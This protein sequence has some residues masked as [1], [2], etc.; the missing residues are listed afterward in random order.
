MDR[1][2]RVWVIDDDRSIRW[3]L[4]KT[5]EKA[6]MEVTSFESA[7][8]VLSSLDK[9]QP[10][11]VV[12]DIRMPG[13]DGLE[14]LE[15]LH[16]RYP[17]LPV[18]IMTA[19][20][21]LDS[22]VSAYHGGAFEYL[23]K[24]FDVDEAVQQIRRACRQQLTVEEQPQIDTSDGGKE[25][26][27]EAP[28]M[29]EVFRAIGRLARSNITVLINGESGTGKELVAHALHR[30]SSRAEGPFIALNMAAI[31]KDL[32]E[33]EL[34]G[35]ERG[36]FTGAQTRRVGRFEQADSGTLF[37]D[38]IGDMPA[39]L[40]T[41]L[42]RVLADGEFYRVGGHEPVKV[43]VRIIAATHQHLE[44]LVKEGA[45]R[46]DLF[47]RLNV[48]RIHLPSLRQR[49]EDIPLLLNYFLKTA[50]EELAV[51][52]KVLLPEAESYLSQLEWPGNVRQ[53][54]NTARWLTVMASGQEIH[55]DD[56][57]TELKESD[58]STSDQ[59]DWRQLLRGWV[60]RRLQEGCEGI[61]NEAEPD[62]ETVM[63]ET[64][65]EHTAGKRQ[66]AARLL[67]W[68]RNTLTRKIKELG[69]EES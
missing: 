53:L 50:A 29:Q 56:L 66:D 20:S 18:I 36:A 68:G 22:A 1:A 60:K 38:E 61:L 39:E 49:R 37:L 26:I 48:I 31:P 35:H 25:I 4:E 21:D 46:E 63:I 27:G 67:G 24:P 69:M 40:Q 7:D 33:S 13:M 59:D 42:L 54:E 3:V 58:T 5:L 9:G 15:L 17:T 11:V 23:P 30:H 14:L 65:L 52:Y 64:A 57:P 34:F 41:R 55:I 10:D 62:F 45:F 47:H 6:D 28:A 8:S 44:G 51:D 32:M 43:D 16:A 19:H 12:S 2:C